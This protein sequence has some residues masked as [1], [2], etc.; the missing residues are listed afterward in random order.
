MKQSFLSVLLNRYVISAIIASVIIFI[1]PDYFSKYAIKLVKQDN[2]NDQRVFYKDLDGD[3]KSEKI[4]YYKN[5]IGNACYMVHAPEGDLLDQFN[6]SGDFANDKTKALWFLDADNNKQLEIYNLTKRKDSIF[7]NIQEPFVKNGIYKKEAFID[8]I[9]PFN[10]NYDVTEA[11]L[12]HLIAKENDPKVVFSLNTG[13]AANPRHVYSYDIFNNVL[14]KS[15]HLVNKSYIRTIED[16]DG[17]NS[18]E[19]ILQSHSSDNTIDPKYTD[20]S[21]ASSWLTVLNSDLEFSFSPVEFKGIS[22]SLKTEVI[23][24]ESKTVLVILFDSNQASDRPD[25]L[26]QY[27]S[28]LKEFATLDLGSGSYRLFADD[29]SQSI[30]TYNRNNG[31]VDYYDYDF[32]LTNTNQISS[33]GNLY[34]EDLDND[35][36]LE[37]LLL[38]RNSN[39]FQ[40]Y[41]NDFS[42]VLKVQFSDLTSNR[43]VYGLKQV[44]TQENQLYFQKG[45]I[46]YIY[47]Y[48]KNPLHALQYLIYLGIYGLVLGF[49]M[50]IEKGQNIRIEKQ[51]AIEAEIAELQLKTIKNQVDPHFVF[52]SINTISE[53]ILMDNKIEVDRFIGRFSGFMRDT[54]QQSDKISTTL[55]DELTYVEN[56]INLQ[57]LRFSN[58]FDYTI[59]VDATVN[60]NFLVPKHVLFTYVENAIKHSLAFRKEGFLTITAKNEKNNLVLTVEDN[61]LGLNPSASKGVGTGNGLKIMKKLFALY[62]KLY[63]HKIEHQ[64]IDLALISEHT[65]IRVEIRIAL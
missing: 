23:I 18:F 51:R 32:N 24:K 62:T 46:A 25:Q 38:S 61:G 39:E 59:S 10:D 47:D 48:I 14:K 40:V 64:V 49:V 15:Q 54:L 35:G 45:N 55:K 5:N 27:S 31:I 58:A 65:G 29:V 21:D 43:L 4:T 42:D 63:K 3:S 44:N 11:E 57:R 26:I 20:R 13:F 52:N 8:V 12:A 33:N 36:L 22:S 7:L 56:F 9:T 37:W 2:Y 1:L 16:I 30:I 60:E 19:I 6:F 53:M 17:D 34:Q 28:T 50:L 41:R